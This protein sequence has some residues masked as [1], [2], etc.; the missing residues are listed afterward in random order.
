MN[1]DKHSEAEDILVITG[2]NFPPG[3]LEV[4]L[5]DEEWKPVNSIGKYW[6]SNFGRVYSTRISA[7]MKPQRHQGYWK[8]CIDKDCL[9]LHRLVAQT[10][11][12]NP[13]N[14]PEVNHKI[15]PDH[16]EAKNLEWV[17]R[18][19]NM[20]H[21]ET[22]VKA[23]K[24]K[25]KIYRHDPVTEEVLQTYNGWEEA[26][27]EGYKTDAVRRRCKRWPS[28]KEPY[29]GFLW[30]NQRS[31]GNVM[32]EVIP[33][34]EWRRTED[35]I[36]NKVKIFDGYQVSNMGRLRKKNGH[37][38][39][40]NDTNERYRVMLYS[41]NHPKGRASF[42]VYQLVLMAFNVPQPTSEH[43]QVDHIDSDCTN[44]KISNLRW[45]TLQEQ[46]SNPNTRK[47]ISNAK[48]RFSVT[49]TLA[50]GATKF[51]KSLQAFR[52]ETKIMYQTIIEHAKNK[53][54]LRGMVISIQRIKD[55]TN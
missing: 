32:E 50:D 30:S 42:L 54:P 16:N 22:K 1:E 8:I 48:I 35:S 19:E 53:Q 47:K 13:Q 34:E 5:R 6:V 11:I 25:I 43:C 28:L 38:M 14:K 37:P 41:P 10:W 45:A 4:S 31:A 39:E 33:E 17:T 52:D 2:Y 49:V 24:N 29:K 36:Y 21:P 9:L 26:S 7:V 12:P 51:Y 15:S 20:N 23:V 44:N 55:I 40:L 3:L 46:R 27:K 18:T